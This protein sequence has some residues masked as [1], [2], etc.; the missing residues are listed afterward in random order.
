MK[1]NRKKKQKLFRK[2]IRRNMEK[3][4]ISK[5]IKYVI[6]SSSRTFKEIPGKEI[7]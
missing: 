6:D 4:A 7:C 2:N 5:T 1:K 3:G